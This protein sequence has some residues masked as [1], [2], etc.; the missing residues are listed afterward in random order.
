MNEEAIYK[1]STA[2]TRKV[3]AQSEIKELELN[4]KKNQELLYNQTKR[5][6]EADAE[7]VERI[8]RL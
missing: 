3:E 7:K 5:S 6:Q 4:L 2:R 1:L 8:N